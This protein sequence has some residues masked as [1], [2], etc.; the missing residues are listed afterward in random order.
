LDRIPDQRN[1]TGVD[2]TVAVDVSISMMGTAPA[3]RSAGRIPGIPIILRD[4]RTWIAKM[5]IV[6][7]LTDDVAL[8]DTSNDA[9]G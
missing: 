8:G 9:P 1:I 3:G 2:V 6:T 5:V 4:S 7:G